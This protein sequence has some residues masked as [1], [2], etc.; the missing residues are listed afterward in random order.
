MT[1]A[2]IAISLD[3]ELARALRKAAKGEPLSAW[4]ADAARRKLRAAGLRQV[5]GDWEDEH[6]EISPAELVLAAKARGLRGETSAR[7]RRSNQP[8]KRKRAAP[9][10][11][12]GVD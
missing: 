4:I 5:I 3:A 2:R 1:V 10:R 7:P 11:V 6:G 9:P 8:R 12:S